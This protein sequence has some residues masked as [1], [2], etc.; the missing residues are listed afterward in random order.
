MSQPAA[1]FGVACP[2]RG[3]CVHY[4]QVELP[5]QPRHVRTCR[6]PEGVFPLFVAVEPRRW[7]DAPVDGDGSEID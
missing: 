3:R 5:E 4:A 6:T 7:T 2:K 1:C